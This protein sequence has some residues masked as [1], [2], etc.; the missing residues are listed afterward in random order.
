L[1]LKAASVVEMGTI[2]R[3]LTG[4]RRRTQIKKEKQVEIERYS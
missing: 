3:L 1:L 4:R 2:N